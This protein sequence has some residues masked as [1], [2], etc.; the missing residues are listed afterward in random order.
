MYLGKGGFSR[1]IRA[2]RGTDLFPLVVICSFLLIITSLFLVSAGSDLT[3]IGKSS[4]QLFE[5]LDS[6]DLVGKEI[7]S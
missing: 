6:L 3:T 2:V 1:N 7:F 5:E 4:C